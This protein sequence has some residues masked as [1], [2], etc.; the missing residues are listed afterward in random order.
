MKE[1]NFLQEMKKSL[2][3][4]LKRLQQWLQ[5]TLSERAMH[6][7]LNKKGHCIYYTMNICIC[8]HSAPFTWYTRGFLFK[9]RQLYALNRFSKKLLLLYIS[10]LAVQCGF[11]FQKAN[12]MCWEVSKPYKLKDRVIQRKSVILSH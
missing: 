5:T 1:T 10:P 4:K 3:S 2:C 7:L 8:T 6:I 11:Y 9:P 12:S